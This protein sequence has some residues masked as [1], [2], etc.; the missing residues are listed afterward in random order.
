MQTGKMILAAAVMALSAN[1]AQAYFVDVWEDGGN[2]GK[3]TVR[4]TG[5]C[6][7]APLTFNNARL[8]DIYESDGGASVGYG[9]VDMDSGEIISYEHAY[10]LTKSIWQR[11]LSDSFW[12]GT[13]T[14][15]V[16]HAGSPSSGFI[17]EATGCSIE[18]IM[19]VSSSKET[20]SYTGPDVGSAEKESSTLQ[21]KLTGFIYRSCNIK[22]SNTTETE[23]CKAKPF[24][25]IINFKGGD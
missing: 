24:N 14:W 4:I 17:E 11:R 15:F 16:D 12:K 18:S 7:T 5:G 22:T 25:A 1:A 2:V 19:P 10:S 21:V 20:Y 6:A 9:L 23:I 13:D 8:G 3:A